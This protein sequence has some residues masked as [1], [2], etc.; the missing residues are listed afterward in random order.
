M[1]LRQAKKIIKLD[2]TLP[3]AYV[4]NTLLGGL[5]H[6]AASLRKAGKQRRRWLALRSGTVERAQRAVRR[7]YAWQKFTVEIFGLT[8]ADLKRWRPR[9]N[10][11]PTR[12]AADDPSENSID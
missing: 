5:Y 11:K 8:P 12:L 6:R 1:K 9:E 3:P 2:T 4:W 10:V 7:H